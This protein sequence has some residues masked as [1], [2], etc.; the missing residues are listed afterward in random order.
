M[1]VALLSLSIL[2]IPLSFSCSP[3]GKD[4]PGQENICDGVLSLPCDIITSTKTEL[5]GVWLLL[6]YDDDT[7]V[8]CLDSATRFDALE[9]G[10]DSI[11]AY[12]NDGGGCL[13]VA[14]GT[15]T[16][17]NDRY[18]LTS[19]WEPDTMILQD[20][21][22]IA[23]EHEYGEKWCSYYGYVGSHLPPDWPTEVC[24]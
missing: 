5:Q 6:A 21:I 19:E 11:W 20:G 17:Y 10:S 16:K 23:Y 8:V 24:Q 14:R 22:I 1:K 12:Y 9:I 13:Y 3:T 4:D 7:G 2:L 15:Y 18:A